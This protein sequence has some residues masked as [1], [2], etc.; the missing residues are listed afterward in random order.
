MRILFYGGCHA[1][2]LNRHFKD[3][4][5]QPVET[6]YLVNFQLIASGR[7]FPY[8]KL[9]EY[10]CVA[11]SPI[12]N[13][14]EYNTDA[15]VEHC[16]KYGIQTV[17]YPW[18]EW[19]G[20][21]PTATKGDFLGHTQ[22]FYPDLLRERTEFKTFPDF[23]EFVVDRFPN[24]QAI[25]DILEKSSAILA[26]S[27]ER[28]NTDVKIS[29]FI[30]DEFR[31]SRLFLISDHPSTT[32]YLCVMAKLAEAIGVDFDRERGSVEDDAQWQWEERMPIFPRV[33]ERL[34]L[35][36]DDRVWSFH[37]QFPGATLSL[38]KYLRLY[39]H[40]EGEIATSKVAT[41]LMPNA[42]SDVAARQ[43]DAGARFLVDRSETGKA[44]SLQRVKIIASLGG[45]GSDPAS[46]QDFFIHAQN[47][48]FHR[49]NA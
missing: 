2:I 48:E 12:E 13:K 11:F 44:Q 28:N 3:F 21:C 29:S 6:D 49:V 47:W 20:Y 31:K 33:R 35:Q 24:D 42:D 14:G 38:E 7:P 17:S 19:H 23:V 39:F 43:V 22:W 30:R 16:R 36:F 18:L 45:E 15:L 41:L 4:V 25:D 37:S 1:L 32:L 26:A 34:G 5:R 40:C 46:G 9:T 10:D 8:E 27:E